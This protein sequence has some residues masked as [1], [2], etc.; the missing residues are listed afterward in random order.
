MLGF[1]IVMK[2]KFRAIFEQ[3]YQDGIRQLTMKNK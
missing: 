1:W 2:I 3:G